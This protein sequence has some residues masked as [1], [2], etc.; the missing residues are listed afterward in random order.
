MESIKD[1][2]LHNLQHASGSIK[3]RKI[4]GRGKKSGHGVKCGKGSNGNKQRSGYKFKPG[5]EGGQ[6]PLKKKLPMIRIINKF[7][8][9]KPKTVTTDMLLP[10]LK[11]GIKEI[12]ECTLVEERII[13]KKENY[14]LVMGKNEDVDFKGLNIVASA[15]SKGVKEFIE[16]KKGKCS[17]INKSKKKIN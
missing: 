9:D 16:R 12:N 15:F 13:K 8:K 14:K 5:F 11:S 4:V 3:K 10:L 2:K 7:R 17:L 6:T 1:I